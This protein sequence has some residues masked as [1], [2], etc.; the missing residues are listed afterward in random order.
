VVKLGQVGKK[1]PERETEFHTAAAENQYDRRVAQSLL[2]LNNKLDMIERA[3]HASLNAEILE[4]M[5]FF[6][7]L[8]WRKVLLVDLICLSLPLISS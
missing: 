1:Q 8:L 3:F 6:M 7:W 2:S 4:L 5:P